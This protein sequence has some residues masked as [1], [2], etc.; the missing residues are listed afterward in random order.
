MKTINKTNSSR[1]LRER[2]SISKNINGYKTSKA[3]NA[4]M[5][6]AKSSLTGT[7]KISKKSVRN[8][9]I[10][11]NMTSTDVRNLTLELVE[12]SPLSESVRDGKMSNSVGRKFELKERKMKDVLGNISKYAL[13]AIVILSVALGQ[14]TPKLDIRIEDQKV[15]LSEAEKKDASLVSYIPGDTV[16]YVIIASNIGD[17]LMTNPEIVDPVPAGVTYVAESASG[18]DTEISFS[19]NQGS[20]YMAWPPYYTVRN[21]KGILVKREATPDMITHVKWHIS[22]KLNPGDATTMEFLVVVNK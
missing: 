4:G 11:M 6:A 5:N 19:M 10:Q 15:N 9:T 1:T 22:K 13:S 8:E 17:G 3:R 18:A 20:T 12:N 2:K 21:S 7:W 16:R 14:G